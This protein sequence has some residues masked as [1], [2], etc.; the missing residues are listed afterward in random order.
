MLEPLLCKSVLYALRNFD[1]INI[2][3]ICQYLISQKVLAKFGRLI[4]GLN[5][6]STF[7]ALAYAFFFVNKISG[8]TLQ[9]YQ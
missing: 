8:I 6:S 2:T 9:L 5:N 1:D 3:T 7:I 4:T